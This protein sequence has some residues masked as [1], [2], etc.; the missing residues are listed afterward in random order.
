MPPSSLDVERLWRFAD[1]TICLM[2]ERD[3]APRFEICVRR[4]E[5]VLRHDRLHSRATA[6]MMAE[7]WRTST[8]GQTHPGF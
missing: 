6:R 1:G 2:I 7:S 5:D 3:V 8:G 4:G